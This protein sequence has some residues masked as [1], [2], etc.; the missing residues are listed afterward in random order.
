MINSCLLWLLKHL[1][2]EV[3]SFFFLSISFRLVNA[4]STWTQTWVSE[5]SWTWVSDLAKYSC[6][7]QIALEIRKKCLVVMWVFSIRLGKKL[8]A[9]VSL[10]TLVRYFFA[11]LFSFPFSWNF[12][13]K[14]QPLF[15][16]FIYFGF[17]PTPLPGIELGLRGSQTFAV[18]EPILTSLL[19]CL[20]NINW[21]ITV[22]HFFIKKNLTTYGPFSTIKSIT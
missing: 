3:S 19:N 2:I 9:Q 17:G 5:S 14:S 20:W 6:T 13:N 12:G 8:W 7:W 22:V 4:S 18:Q 11:L 10:V 15:I 1:A 21:R 16:L